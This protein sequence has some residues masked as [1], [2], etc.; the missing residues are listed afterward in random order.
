M[1]EIIT[2]GGI[3][4]KNKKILLCKRA[5]GEKRYPFCW[6]CP[7]GRRDYPD[8]S[9]EKMAIR[10]VKEESGFDFTPKKLFG[11]YEMDLDDRKVIS[12]L[13][14]GEFSGN[15]NF[16]KDEVE[17]CQWFTYEE[18]KK[19]TLSFFYEKVLSDLHQQELL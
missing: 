4:I 19:L 17:D 8:E 16:D 7:A 11:I 6:G 9:F 13:Y 12:H 18:T 5:K 3:L 1:K 10:E 15:I 2:A 14:L